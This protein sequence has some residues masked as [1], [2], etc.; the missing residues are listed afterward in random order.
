M[1]ADTVRNLRSQRSLRTGSALGLSFAA[2]AVIQF[3]IQAWLAFSFARHVW[4]L[5]GPLPFAAPVALDAFVVNMMVVTYELRSAKLSVRTYVWAVLFAGVA[6]QVGAAEGYALYAGWGWWAR[7]ASFAP[8]LLL[9]ASLH[10]LIVRRRSRP[11]GQPEP[12]AEPE[13][14]AA[15]KAAAPTVVQT[16]KPV[17]STPMQTPKA[18]TPAPTAAPPTTVRRP[19]PS[20]G[21][22]DE[23][24]AL[25]RK[26]F[27]DGEKIPAIA[28]DLGVNRRSVENWTRDLRTHSHLT[29]G[30]IP[31]GEIG[32]EVALSPK[33]SEPQAVESHSGVAPIK[34][35]NDPSN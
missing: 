35:E 11:D 17:T 10:T 6:L 9:A 22:S 12:T 27:L 16:P 3:A 15:S 26:R 23:T 30:E 14:P 20:H 8:A 32:G 1:S 13:P 24:K 4:H 2:N 18:A 21:V 29:P 19:K 31:P 7:I 28:A 25:A 33:G 5:P 34:V